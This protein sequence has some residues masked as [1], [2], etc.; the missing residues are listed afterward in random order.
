M[1]RIRE[2]RTVV[3][4]PDGQRSYRV[5]LAG[6]PHRHR[7]ESVETWIE[8]LDAQL[9]RVSTYWRRLPREK[10]TG[11]RIGAKALDAVRSRFNEE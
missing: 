8:A 1:A 3:R 7:V 4:V 11:R 9:R 10:P 6:G 5:V 2:R